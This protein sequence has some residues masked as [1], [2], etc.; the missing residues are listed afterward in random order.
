[1]VSPKFWGVPWSGHRTI[2]A[3][4]INSHVTDEWIWFRHVNMLMQLV[5]STISSIPECTLM[6]KK[7]MSSWHGNTFRVIGGESGF[8]SQSATNT[9]FEVCGVRLTKLL[10]KPSRLRRFQTPLLWRHAI[11][12]GSYDGLPPFRMKYFNQCCLANL[13][14]H[15]YVARVRIN[16]ST[17]AFTGV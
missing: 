13:G 9:S 1:M 2:S 16:I 17:E 11:T 12:T 8:P 3:L 5:A 7:T 15:A 14:E 6:L 10:N 4:I